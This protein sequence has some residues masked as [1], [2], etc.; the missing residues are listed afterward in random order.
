LDTL[1]ID[2]IATLKNLEY[3]D[4]KI[5]P[6]KK[7]RIVK[8]NTVIKCN[9][10]S[11]EHILHSEDKQYNTIVD[12]IIN[13]GEKTQEN[14]KNLIRTLEL[15]EALQIKQKKTLEKLEQN[16]D[17][18]KSQELEID[19]K[20]QYLNNKFNLEKIPTKNEIEKLIK[21]ITEKPQELEIQTTRLIERITD[22]VEV[23]KSEIS[24]LKEEID[25][26]KE[27]ALS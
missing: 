7:Y 13:F 8:D 24:V 1:R 18:I 6:E 14:N 25:K 3:L 22:Q 26:I 20:I 23:L 10:S 19:R 17:F 27:I 16:L 11:G 2:N 21:T 5:Y 15:V 4:L 9:F 12:L